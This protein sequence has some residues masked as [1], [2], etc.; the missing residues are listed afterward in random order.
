MK[1]SDQDQHYS[2]D[3]SSRAPSSKSS[4]ADSSSCFSSSERGYSSTTKLRSSSN[5][6][7]PAVVVAGSNSVGTATSS[8][9]ILMT[10]KKSADHVATT[11]ISTISSEASLQSSQLLSEQGSGRPKG[12][13]TPTNKTQVRIIPNDDEREARK[14]GDNKGHE[15]IVDKTLLTSKTP[16]NM[17][18]SCTTNNTILNNLARDDDDEP[19]AP[20]EASGEKSIEVN[21]Q[22]RPPPP[23]AKKDSSNSALLDEK[24]Q[25]L[26]QTPRKP[27]CDESVTSSYIDRAEEIH[28]PASR[29]EQDLISFYLNGQVVGPFPLKLQTML[30]LAEKLGMQDIIGWQPHGRSFCIRNP[31]IFEAGL[32]K[33]FFK[34]KEL[35]SF[36]RQL[37]LY[38]FKRMK[39]GPDSGS[40]Y[41]EMFLRGKPF[42]AYKMIRTKVKGTAA[43]AAVGNS[44]GHDNENEPNFYR[45]PFLPP[46]WNEY[47]ASVSTD[48]SHS[49]T[50]AASLAAIGFG[51]VTA[52]AGGHM[53]TTM[54]TSSTSTGSSMS[55]MPQVGSDIFDAAS[56][57]LSNNLLRSQQQ[58]SLQQQP[59]QEL[60]HQ[61]PSIADIAN[62]LPL[63]NVGLSQTF[64]PNVLNRNNNHFTSTLL[65][66]LVRG[67]AQ[68][69]SHPTPFPSR[70]SLQTNI[71]INNNSDLRSSYFGATVGA[72]G[73]QLNGNISNILDITSMPNYNNRGLNASTAHG[74]IM[75]S[76]YS[77]NTGQAPSNFIGGPMGFVNDGTYPM[78][79]PNSLSARQDLFNLYNQL[80][81]SSL[82]TEGLASS[83]IM[84]NSN[85]VQMIDNAVDASHN[86]ARDQFMNQNYNNYNA[87]SDASRFGLF[88]GNANQQMAAGP[89]LGF[90]LGTQMQAHSEAPNTVNN[91][92]S[93][94]LVTGSGNMN[95]TAEPS[96]NQ[97]HTSMQNDSNSKSS[98]TNKREYP[99][100]PARPTSN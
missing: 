94:N 98:M 76:D 43:A 42:H 33:R 31:A 82:S 77:N 74:H 30:R 97:Q 25:Q 9:R 23:W 46:C 29:G 48:A 1:F 99:N 15:T 41:H 68:Q 5:S 63:F 61:H 85:H 47:I 44:R 72:N 13:P 17:P 91:L 2:D 79:F 92:S 12:Y 21:Y 7:P 78:N 3:C 16:S 64:P 20:A 75:N 57:I 51:D 14:P 95:S 36:R 70:D 19:E 93:L 89:N 100:K 35:A 62:L 84:G 38:D 24:K 53:L 32:M 40:Y 39:F 90:F 18:S 80:Q 22:N 81:Y 67:P 4:K 65:G 83:L 49:D 56:S 37:N 58:D 66:P 50:V 45:L 26:K 34:Q 10:K 55:I 87:A 54:P 96:L 28:L 27:S 88:G 59:Q 8:S 69:Q 60:E 73:T 6:A 52:I 86:S 11:T 71:M